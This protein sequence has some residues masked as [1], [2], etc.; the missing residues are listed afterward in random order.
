MSRIG[1][2]RATMPV[3]AAVRR[4]RQHRNQHERRF[5][6]SPPSLPRRRP[7]PAAGAA[8][9]RGSERPAPPC[10][11]EPLSGGGA[12]IG[13]STSGGSLAPRPRPHVAPCCPP[14]CAAPWRGSD[15]LAPPCPCQPLSAAA[16]SI[17]AG[18]SGAPPGSPPSPAC[19]ALVPAARAALHRGSDRLA[20]PCPCQPLSAAATSIGAG[21]SGGPL[22]PHP[23]LHVAPC[24]PPTPRQRDRAPRSPLP[25]SGGGGLG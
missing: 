3:R 21:T 18:T 11:C 25:L 8:P 7:V 10:P 23:R 5:L 17:G 14:P 2:P 13:T 22:A 6:G 12:S 9:W 16:T 19:G 4:W 1:S 15:R 20:P 24:C